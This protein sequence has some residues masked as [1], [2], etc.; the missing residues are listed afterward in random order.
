MLG[1]TSKTLL[2][3]EKSRGEAEVFAWREMDVFEE[4]KLDSFH[5][6]KGQIVNISNFVNPVKC[7]SHSLLLCVCVCVCCHTLK[8]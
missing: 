5:V 7:Q 4:L 1:V 2:R 6:V 3:I 8:M